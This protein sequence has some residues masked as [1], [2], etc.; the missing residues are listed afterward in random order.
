MNSRLS[1]YVKIWILNYLNI[2]G[3]SEIINQN[4]WWKYGKDFQLQLHPSMF[5][6]VKKNSF[7]LFKQ[8]LASFSLLFVS[9]P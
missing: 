8:Y 1:K 3:I 9:S 5:L 6:T 7:A 4:P 2:V